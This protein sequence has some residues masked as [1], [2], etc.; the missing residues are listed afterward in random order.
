LTEEERETN[1]LGG[2]QGPV[3]SAQD[4][5]AG[6]VIF[7]PYQKEGESQTRYYVAL[8]AR[9][10]TGWWDLP[11]GHLEEGE[12]DEEAAVREV[13]EETGLHG[14]I[15]AGLGESRYVYVKDAR[16]APVR[17]L[18]RWYLMRD[19]SEEFKQPIPQPG[20]TQDAIW[21]DLNNAIPLVYFDNTRAILRR[22][23]RYLQQK[24]EEE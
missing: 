11:K 8:I 19:T 9:N 22:A 1:I 15:V 7:R 21:C 3:E 4:R 6:G 17:K 2:W 12:I 5:S 14:E 13:A 18:V 10:H 24:R 20:E 23:R 16:Q